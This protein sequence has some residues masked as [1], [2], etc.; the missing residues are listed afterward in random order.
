[1]RNLY[2]A[3]AR[4]TNKSKEDFAGKWLNRSKNNIFKFCCR[5][6][7]LCG[8]LGGHKLTGGQNG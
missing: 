2:F 3:A 5:F 4:T 8:G 1:M 7:L 6:S